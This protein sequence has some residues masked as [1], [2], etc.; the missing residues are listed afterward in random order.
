MRLAA[1]GAHDRHRTDPIC[2]SIL[3]TTLRCERPARDAAGLES[4]P[5]N[6]A[7]ATVLPPDTEAPTA[8]GNLQAT[9]NGTSSVDLSWDAATDNRAVT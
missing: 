3:R 7:T 9:L 4:G 5:S 6:S 8:P 2:C 1:V